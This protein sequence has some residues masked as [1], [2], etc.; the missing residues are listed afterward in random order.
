MNKDIDLCYFEIIVFKY[1]P[2]GEDFDLWTTAYFSND[3]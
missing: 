3:H 1:M 2:S